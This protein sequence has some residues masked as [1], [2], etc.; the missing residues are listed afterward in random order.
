MKDCV[1]QRQQVYRLDVS[2]GH[3]WQT[4]RHSVKFNLGDLGPQLSREQAD[5]LLLGISQHLMGTKKE[6]MFKAYLQVIYSFIDPI[7]IEHQ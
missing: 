7:V 5:S 4:L 3:K 2:Q 1:D 6:P